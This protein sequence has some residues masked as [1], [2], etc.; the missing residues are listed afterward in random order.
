[1][2]TIHL[3]ATALA[4]TALVAPSAEAR[5]WGVHTIATPGPALSRGVD[6]ASNGRAAVL[7]QRAARGSNRLELR[8]GGRTR[9]LD[10]SSHAFLAT[11]VQHDARGRLVVVWRRILGSAIQAFA[12]TPRGG[13]QQVSDVHKS[14]SHLSLSVAPSGRA[15]LAYWS[16]EGVFVARGA[17]GHGFDAP[18]TVAPAG[19]YAAQPGAAVSRSGRVVVAWSDGKRIMVRAASGPGPFGPAQP[20]ALRPPGTGNTV[21]PGVPKIVMTSG[22]RAVVAVSSFEL[23]GSSPVPV[24]TPVVVDQRVE[25]FD[26]PRKAARPSTASTLSRGATAG[27]AAVVVQGAS[28]MIAW[29]QRPQGAPRALWVTRW[30]RAGLQRPN[31]Y[32]TH[33]LRLPVLLTRG[34]RGAV[35]AFYQ[36]G[37]QRWF[38]VRL[39]AAGLYRGTSSVTP[40]GDQIPLIDVAAEGSRAIAGW[41]IGKRSS[42]VQLAR[43][44]R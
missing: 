42:R 39:S 17:S 1:M 30:T 22:G 31:V 34:P 14:V 35:D 29:T 6:V 33:D 32:D 18:T 38:T 23:R 12:W 27:T 24:Q 7:L 3:S 11:D 37:G 25:A 19:T 15:V 28:A 43:P 41:T 26:W 8:V 5:P 13:R 40:L 16:P 36:A 44:A 9:L 2:K 4:A 20:V 21:V 10:T